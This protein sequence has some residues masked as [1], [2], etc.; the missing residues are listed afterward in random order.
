MKL[1]TFTL[2]EQHIKLLRKMWVIWYDCEAG[3]PGVDCKR[4]Y[5]NSDVDGDMA[6]ILGLPWD[7]EDDETAVE[8]QRAFTKLHA[9]TQTALQIVLYTGKFEP[10]LYKQ[11]CEYDSQAWVLVSATPT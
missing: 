2:T 1:K 10:G 4:P 6:E 3:A 9:E 8:Q 5:G 7:P 11:Q